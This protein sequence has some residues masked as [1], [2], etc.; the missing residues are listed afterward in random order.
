MDAALGAVAEDRRGRG[1]GLVPRFRV[2]LLRADV[3]RHAP[4]NDRQLGGAAQA[5]GLTMKRV[6]WEVLLALAALLTV[7]SGVCGVFGL[8][9][10][11]PSLGDEG[12][13]QMLWLVLACTAAG[14]IPGLLLVRLAR[15]RLRGGTSGHGC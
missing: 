8:A 2:A 9:L 11:A 5:A 14:L 7:G 6:I 4:R 10:M 13:W 12:A 1:Q 15:K 3:E